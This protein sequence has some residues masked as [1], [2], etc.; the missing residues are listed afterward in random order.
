M[1]TTVD[2]V[3][4]VQSKGAQDNLKGTAKAAL[5]LNEGLIATAGAAG[6]VVTAMG[7]LASECWIVTGKHNQQ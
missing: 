2:Y 6:A 5:G 1:A 4:K 7:T 3:L